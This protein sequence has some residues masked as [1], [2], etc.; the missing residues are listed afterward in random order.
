MVDPGPAPP[1]TPSQF[2]NNPG[3]KVYKRQIKNQEL[4]VILIVHVSFS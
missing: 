3:F 1:Y 2:I 4:N